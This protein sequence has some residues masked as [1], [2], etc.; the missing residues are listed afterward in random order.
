MIG[1]L[2]IIC[3]PMWSGKTT[4]LLRLYD[5]NMHAEVPSLLIRHS[6]D[7]RYDV[8]DLDG[9]DSLEAESSRIKSHMDMSGKQRQSRAYSCSTILDILPLVKKHKIDAVFIDEIQFFPDK[10]H[11]SVLLNMGV[12]VIVAGLNGDFR[13]EMFDGM[14]ELYSQAY[15]IKMLRAVCAFC[16]SE[17]ACYTI[18][19]N[20]D[21]DEIQ[22]VGGAEIYKA[23]CPT[24]K[25]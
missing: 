19:H 10:G 24:C 13:Q 1:H 11:C 21:S 6:I 20:T 7:T 3:G 15:D 5:R 25:Q 14:A 2:S 22:Q 12:H 4:E 16:K 17:D 9:V 23:C 8:D 18:K